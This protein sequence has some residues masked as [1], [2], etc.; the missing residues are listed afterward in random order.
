MC[1]S[2][3]VNDLLFG[4]YPFL[5]LPALFSGIGFRSIHFGF[6]LLAFWWIRYDTLHFIV[7][8]ACPDRLFYITMSSGLYS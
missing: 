5:L 3:L 7:Y 8:Y 2:K 4:L 1:A 6:L